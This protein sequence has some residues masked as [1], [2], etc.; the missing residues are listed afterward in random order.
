LVDDRD[1]PR[2][3]RRLVRRRPG[4]RQ[5]VGGG[6]G[7]DRGVERRQPERTRVGGIVRPEPRVGVGVE[8]VDAAAAEREGGC[9]EED[10][11]LREA[12]SL[13]R[14]CTN[15]VRGLRPDWPEAT[16]RGLALAATA[17]EDRTARSV[18]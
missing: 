12:Y 15:P 6:H 9:T 8:L 11:D 18:A 4:K 14:L 16:E 7:H 1:A 5:V 10:L 2:L 3:G 17:L 13:L